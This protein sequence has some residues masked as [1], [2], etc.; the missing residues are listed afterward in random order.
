VS[1]I[2]DARQAIADA[3]VAGTSL[4]RCSPYPTKRL[5]PPHALVVDDDDEVNYDL[6]FARGADAYNFVVQVY[7][8][9]TDDQSTQALF[10]DLADP[11]ETGL[12]YAVENDTT[13]AALID[14]AVVRSASGTGVVTIGGTEYLLKSFT[15]EVV[16]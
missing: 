12:K 5:N 6:V 9:F 3:V 13:L 1:T 15:V 4:E 2:G 16:F 14:Y 8:Q 10:D 11:G 7:G